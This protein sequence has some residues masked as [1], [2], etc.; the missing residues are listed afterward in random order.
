[1]LQGGQLVK[2]TEQTT[3]ELI[4]A[5]AKTEFL[6]KGFQSA[7]LRNIVKTAGVTTG[8]FYGY[9]KSKEQ[10][11]E[12][13]VGRQYA[14]FL[15]LFC[16]AQQNFA[17]LPKDEQP[18]HMGDISGQCMHDM[19]IYAY[20]NPEEFKL[21]LCCSEGTRFADMIDKMV[22]IETKSTHD[23]LNVLKSLGQPAPPIDP[24]LEH[25]LITGMFNAFFEMIIHEMPL[26]QAE[27]Y[28]LELRAFYTAGWMK[29]M[30]QSD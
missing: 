10:L 29:I 5:A 3:L 12:A 8:A 23:Y 16:Q 20:Q 30:G 13:L 17:G 18:D 11:F 26:A 7:S 24:H 25:I 6:E 14:Q 2:N 21:I 1:M 4:H 22:D 9:Y 27:A 19:L 28:L 15:D